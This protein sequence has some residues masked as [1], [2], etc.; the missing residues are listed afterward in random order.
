MQVKV[1][2]L[3]QEVEGKASREELDGKVSHEQ[4]A[5][6]NADLKEQIMTEAMVQRSQ[7]RLPQVSCPRSPWQFFPSNTAGLTMHP[8]MPVQG[9][10]EA[11]RV[12]PPVP[13]HA[14]PPT[15]NRKR[16]AEQQQQ[17]QGDGPTK[18]ARTYEGW[19]CCIQ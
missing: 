19:P 3:A 1:F 9:G 8:F 2:G 13:A 15:L 6:S 12:E 4:L 16:S 5:A 14:A 10:G 17:Q 7:G 11:R 18:K